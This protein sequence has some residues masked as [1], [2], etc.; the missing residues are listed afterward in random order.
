MGRIGFPNPL[1]LY[2]AWSPDGDWIAYSVL[3]PGHAD[4]YLINT[5]GKG[6]GKPLLMEE[7]ASSLNLSPAWVPETFFSVSPNT[8]RRLMPGARLKRETD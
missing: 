1:I 5:M 8:E 4:I 6:R 3:E 7:R 2:P